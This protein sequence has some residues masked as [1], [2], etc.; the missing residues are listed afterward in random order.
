M[1]KLLSIFLCV[2]MLFTLAA[3]QSGGSETQDP[4]QTN[5]ST[6]PTT[7]ETEP[8]QT[9]PTKTE[10]PATEP[11]ETEPPETEPPETEP[12]VTEPPETEPP[13]TEPEHPY[14]NLV[15]HFADGVDTT[16]KHKTWGWD[17]ENKYITA[18]KSLECTWGTGGY[19]KVFLVDGVKSSDQTMFEEGAWISCTI[20]PGWGDYSGTLDDSTV[21]WKKADLDEWLIFDLQTMCRVDKVNFSTLYTLGANGMPADFTIQVSND[22]TNWTTVVDITG[23]EQDITSKDQVFPF[24]EVECRYVKL[25]FTKASEKIDDNLA[26]CAALSEVEIWGR[27]K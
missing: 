4:T 17:P 22:K 5:P 13:A 6:E 2:C 16:D 9:E 1:K 15:A 24:K 12:P 19:G 21:T 7:T 26:Y 11:P 23:Y 10:P 18:S 14:T 20:N 3:C 8:M 27:V 25:H